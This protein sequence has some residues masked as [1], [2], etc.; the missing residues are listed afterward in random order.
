MLEAL[1]ASLAHELN[2]PL[3][4]IVTSANAATRWLDRSEPNLE[5]VRARLRRSR[6]RWTLGRCHHRQP[7]QGFPQPRVPSRS[8]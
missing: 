7:A 5:E 8:S 6:S 2:Q 3:A 1:S 4:S